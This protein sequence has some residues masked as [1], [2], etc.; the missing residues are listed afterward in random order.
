[1][2]N[3][4]TRAAPCA[5]I[6]I[7]GSDGRTVYGI[8]V[9][10]DQPTEINDRYN[11]NYTET[12]R[13]GAFARTLTERGAAKVKLLAVH[14]S[15]TFPLGRLSSAVED[16]AGLLIEARV[17]AT[18]AGD[19]ALELVRDGALD[20]F[21]IGFVPVPTGDRW[22]KGRTSV[23]RLEVK[24]HEVSL[25][26]LPPYAGALVA[27]VRSAEPYDPELD[28]DLIARRFRLAHIL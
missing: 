12:F 20:A 17:S 11:G 2:S 19:E 3:I 6:E 22:G 7:R 21:S 26:R 10:F 25:V 4:I 18:Q 15:Q 27:G 16:A 28:P 14:N 23:E 1:M 9:P 5:D 8:A 13:R 24:L